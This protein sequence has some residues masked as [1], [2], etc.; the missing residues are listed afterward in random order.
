MARIALV[1]ASPATAALVEAAATG[2]A[3]LRCSSADIPADA[4]LIIADVPRAAEVRRVVAGLRSAAARVLLLVASDARIE[5]SDLESDRCSVLRNPCDLLV[6]RRKIRELLELDAG[7]ENRG[8]TPI[9]ANQCLSPISGNQCL[10]RISDSAATMLGAAA[11]LAGP[12]WIPG[13]PGTGAEAVADAFAR[14]WDGGREPAVWQEDDPLSSAVGRLDDAGRV[15]WAPAVDR[16][17]MGEQRAFERYLA[18][19]PQR[20]V[21]VTTGDDPDAQVADGS[22]APGLVALLSRI[23]V[24]LAPL[25]ER[26]GDILALASAVAGPVASALGR[27]GCVFTDNAQRLLATYPWPGNVTELEAVVTRSVLGRVVEAP[28][29]GAS[30]EIDAAHLLFAPAIGPRAAA[31]PDASAD[32]PAEPAASTR[33]AV[34]V[35]IASAP[36]PRAAKPSDAASEHVAQ[37]SEAATQSAGPRSTVES[38]LAAFAHDIRNPMSTIKTFAGL[39]ADGGGELAQL[40]TMACE[41]IDGHLDLLQRYAELGTRLPDP[42][43][44][45]QIDLVDV[46]GE[47][48][49]TAGAESALE[50][51]ARGALRV[52]CDVAH[53]RF[54][55]DSIVAECRSRASEPA[56]PATADLATGRPAITIRIPVGGSAID[57]LGKWLGDSEMPWRLAIARDAARRAGFDL[58]VR[59]TDGDIEIEWHASSAAE[60]SEPA[61]LQ[62][63]ASSSARGSAAAARPKAKEQ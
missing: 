14:S 30:V 53:A 5:R 26:S 20:R 52:R 63:T 3:I 54:I 2:N 25:R 22:L 29:A 41:A 39:Q 8:Q 33:R 15:L 13:E 34:V 46:L 19:N 21:V 40:A 44:V 61:P 42:A 38:V 4:E 11:R 37:A 57:R 56:I 36:P 58:D 9:S 62:R 1:D 45:Q 32:A 28:D 27:D 43:S 12:V 23:T 35:P 60:V 47:A 50:V 17:P 59:A 6:L 55:A 18:V 49:E 16:R 48:V 7:D 10:S 31:Q 51:A 24:R